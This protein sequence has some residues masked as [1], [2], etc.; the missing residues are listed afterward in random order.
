MRRNRERR[1][2]LTLPVVLFAHV[3]V[4]LVVLRADRERPIINSWF[5]LTELEI[6]RFPLPRQPPEL[7]SARDRTHRPLR[8]RDR[9]PPPDFLPPP[10]VA[11][12]PP[13]PFDW[14]GAAARAAQRGV[15]ELERQGA[16]NDFSGLSIAQRGWIK[17]N[18]LEPVAPGIPW[19]PPRVEVTPEGLPIIHVN[20]H[21]IVVPMLAFLMFCK[22]GHIGSSAH[23]FDHMRDVRPR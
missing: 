16:S 19:G 4:F 23:I 21:C 14:Q 2:A 12:E 3:L 18:H 6:I 11:L 1:R 8:T 22:I 10:A 15:A 13:A 20:E 5:R 17:K 9:V 7:P